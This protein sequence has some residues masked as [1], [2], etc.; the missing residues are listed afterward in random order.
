M[1]YWLFLGFL[2][3]WSEKKVSFVW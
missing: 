1:S 3:I 2:V